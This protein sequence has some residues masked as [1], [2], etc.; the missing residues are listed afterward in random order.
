MMERASFSVPY[1]SPVPRLW[2]AE[3]LTSR[4][5]RQNQHGNFTRAVRLAE[6]GYV[7]PIIPCVRVVTWAAW[8]ALTRPEL[9]TRGFMEDP[10]GYYFYYAAF[11]SAADASTRSPQMVLL[12]RA[13]FALLKSC[14]AKYRSDIFL[15]PLWSLPH[16]VS[17]RFVFVEVMPFSTLVFEFS[18][19]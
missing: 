8:K 18:V 11:Y 7:H 9:L 14:F 19:Y 3:A 4:A 10:A 5:L 15:H 6:S 2:S 13:V 17:L 12:R 16:P 1:G